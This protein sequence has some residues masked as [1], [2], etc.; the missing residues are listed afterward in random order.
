MPIPDMGFA[1]EVLAAAMPLMVGSMLIMDVPEAIFIDSIAQSAVATV[2]RYC[3][4]VDT[5]NMKIER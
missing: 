2:F 3:R 1:V 4:F 5:G